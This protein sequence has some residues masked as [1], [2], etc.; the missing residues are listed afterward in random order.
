MSTNTTSFALPEAEQRL[1][2]RAA[3]GLASGATCAVTPRRKALSKEQ[4]LCG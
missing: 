1:R 4:A 2:E 3:K